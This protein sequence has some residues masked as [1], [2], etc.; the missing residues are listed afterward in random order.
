M[1]KVF[2]KD[3][4]GNI[5]FS[6]EGLKDIIEEVFWEGYNMP[7]NY[8]YSSPYCR[9]YFNYSGTHG[10]FIVSSPDSLENN[11]GE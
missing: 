8:V 11:K 2:V 5:V 1:V 6:E 10:S 7:H 3:D 4:N 9:G